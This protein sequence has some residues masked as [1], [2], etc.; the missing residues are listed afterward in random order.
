MVR[1]ILVGDPGVELV[2]HHGRPLARRIE[3]F[4]EPR[5]AVAHLAQAS[6]ILGPEPWRLAQAEPDHHLALRG[7]VAAQR[8]GF[9]AQVGELAPELA[10]FR[11][12]HH[13]LE[14][15]SAVDQLVDHRPHAGDHAVA[16]HREELARPARAVL[17]GQRRAQVADRRQGAVAQGHDAVRL[18]PDAD[19]DH[20]LGIGARVEIDSA[21]RDQEGLVDCKLAR[22][23]LLGQQ[24]I[25]DQGIEATVLVQPAP[26]RAPDP[27]EVQPEQPLL[28]P[29]GADLG[30]AELPAAAPAIEQVSADQSVLG[31]RRRP[32]QHLDGHQARSRPSRSARHWQSP[33]GRPCR[34]YPT[35]A[36]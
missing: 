18:Q 34:F 4:D 7:E 2:L 9:T 12:Q 24:R 31:R 21:Q 1:F 15:I 28:R 5:G 25:A 35:R 11:G 23:D 36:Q 19:P 32:L 17:R 33:P 22:P 6:P 30:P 26:A 8:D 27:V 13:V 10:A 20:V 14:A 29:P 16:Q 3:I